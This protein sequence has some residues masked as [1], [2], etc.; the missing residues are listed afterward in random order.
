MSEENKALGR[1]FCAEDSNG[2]IYNVPTDPERRTILQRGVAIGVASLFLG[3]LGAFDTD[4]LVAGQAGTA[5]A[6]G[7]AI[8]KGVRRVITGHNAQ[9]RSYVVSDDRVTGGA[10]PNLYRATGELPLGPTPTAESRDIRPTT[11]RQLE[12]ALGGSTFTFVTL[13]PT[14]RGA[15]P[16]WHRTETLDYDIVLGGELVLM[17]EEGET[18][19][20][21]G[22]V[23]IQR[24]TMH[25]WRNDTGAPVY[26]VAVL[27]PIRRQP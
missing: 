9:D 1:R 16:G 21:P 4:L 10:H 5:P 7:I 18:K 19:L 23:V 6:P 13:A 25:A 11:N 12:P 26:F 2:G 14:P 24:N 8:S 3:G 17:V 22:D 15:T 20:F 27:V